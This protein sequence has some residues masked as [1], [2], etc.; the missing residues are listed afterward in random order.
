M[1]YK[2]KWNESKWNEMHEMKWITI[3]A[4]ATT[5]TT[6]FVNVVALNINWIGQSN[7][8]RE[9][10]VGKTLRQPAENA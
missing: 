8:R 1:C 3:A 4:T 2:D 10:Q 9:L 5:T 6:Q 7:R